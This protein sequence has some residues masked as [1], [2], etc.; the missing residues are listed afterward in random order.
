MYFGQIEKEVE[1]LAKEGKSPVLKIKIQ[2]KIEFLK[3]E[4]EERSL[5]GNHPLSLKM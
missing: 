3:R 5:K 4:I 1:T 2:V